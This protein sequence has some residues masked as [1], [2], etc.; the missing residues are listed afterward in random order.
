MGHAAYLA[1]LCLILFGALWLEVIVR[2]RVLVR[3][4]RTLLAI[5]PV[6]FLFTLWDWYAVAHGHWHFE[7][8]RV[9]G[10]KLAREL[11]I[12][13]ILFFAVVPLAA[14]LTLEAVRAVRG[15]QVGDEVE[16]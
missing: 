2:T 16:R 14:I 7:S 10:I 12:E 6:S 13:E 8:A 9:T 4:R 3:L 1:V 11:P 15:W 5:L